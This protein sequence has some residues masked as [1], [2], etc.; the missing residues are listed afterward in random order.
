MH[1]LDD[2]NLCEYRHTY[3]LPKLWI[4]DCI[5]LSQTAWSNF[6]QFD[7]VSSKICDAFSVITQNN[8]IT[9]F[10]STSPILVPVESSYCEFL[11]KSYLASFPS[12]CGLG[13]FLLLIG[14]SG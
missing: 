9:P 8:G 5:F 13:H 1:I 3:L 14:V 2:C 7:V 12:Y 6:N 4:M 10:D 11:L